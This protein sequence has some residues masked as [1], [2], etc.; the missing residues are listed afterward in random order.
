M[1]SCHSTNSR[2]LLLLLLL[3]LLPSKALNAV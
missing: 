2:G 1:M 3:L